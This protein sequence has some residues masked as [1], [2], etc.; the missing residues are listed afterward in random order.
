[1]YVNE[2]VR[3]LPAVGNTIRNLSDWFVLARGEPLGD[4]RLESLSQV[5]SSN[6]GI[7]LTGKF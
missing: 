4:L 6:V 7:N 2:N 5:D 3:T 1:M